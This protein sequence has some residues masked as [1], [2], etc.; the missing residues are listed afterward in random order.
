M[1]Q[2]TTRKWAQALIMVFSMRMGLKEDKYVHPLITIEPGEIGPSG[3]AFSF[4]K[5]YG[6]PVT[7]WHK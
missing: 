4:D 6:L 5:R 7:G 3:S 2:T 1:I